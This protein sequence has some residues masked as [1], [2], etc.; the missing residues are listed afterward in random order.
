M[1]V[2]EEATTQSRNRGVTARSRRVF[3]ITVQSKNAHVPES[4]IM[5]A[6]QMAAAAPLP[7]HIQQHRGNKQQP[8]PQQQQQ[9]R[10]HLDM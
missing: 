9:G 5:L 1:H 3:E 8:P 2:Q 10:P 6:G 4:T 7:L